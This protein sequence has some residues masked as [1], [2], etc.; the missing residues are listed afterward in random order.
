MG[1]AG[2]WRDDVVEM[3]V[4]GGLDWPRENDVRLGDEAAGASRF[5][6]N[7]TRTGD[8]ARVCRTH[9]RILKAY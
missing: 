7:S 4:R 9:N 6:A 3:D 1:I 8:F 5:H 2:R